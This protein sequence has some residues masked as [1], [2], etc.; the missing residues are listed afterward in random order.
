MVQSKIKEFEHD[1]NEILLMFDGGKDLSVRHLFNDGEDRFV[2]TIVIGNKSYAFGTLKPEMKDEIE[3]KRI[4][5]RYAK[6]ALYKALSAYLGQKLE[7]GALSGIRPT[8]LAYSEIEKTG[9]FEDFFTG[10]FKVSDEKTALVKSIIEAQKGIYEKKDGN[11]DLF[12]F[13]P[14]CPSRCKYCSFISADVKSAEKLVTPYV[15]ALIY[16]IEKTAPLIKNLRSIYVGGG[17]P[18]ALS[19]ED[20]ERVLTALDKINTG[21]EFTVEAGRPD[22]ITDEKI[23]IME[24]HRV[25]R[26]CVNPQ[27]FND[28]TLVKI[29]RNHTASDV[30]SVYEKVKDKFIVNMDLIAGLNG[31]SLNDFKNSVDA[32]M[33]LNPDNFTVHTLCLKKG[34]ELKETE[35]RLNVKDVSAMIDYARAKAAENGYMPYYVYRQ[36]YAAG[37]LENTGYCKPNKACVYNVDVMEEISDNLA[38]GAGAISKKVDNERE[39]IERVAAPKDVKTYIEKIDKIIREKQEIFGKKA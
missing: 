38:C 27:T 21:V 4:Y 35:E 5:K 32:T 18:V 31:E 39:S 3:K 37:N 19:D 23:K 25:T 17:T 11:T 12:V 30:L 20:F 16:E 29:G 13:I 7:W 2:N 33:A 34:S 36:K 15:D 28:A 14:F 8:K 1:L 26:I 6:L 10:V 9:E 22:V 24:S